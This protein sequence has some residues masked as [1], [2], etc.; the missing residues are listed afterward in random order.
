[1]ATQMETQAIASDYGRADDALAAA[2]AS[3]G[4]GQLKIEGLDS[5]QEQ[6]HLNRENI[7]RCLPFLQD[8]LDAL[9]AIRDAAELGAALRQT[10]GQALGTLV[11]FWTQCVRDLADQDVQLRPG[12][13]PAVCLEP[14]LTDTLELREIMLDAR[15]DLK[16]PRIQG[17]LDQL[18]Q[19]F[20]GVRDTW[21][22][23]TVVE[24]LKAQVLQDAECLSRSKPG[25]GMSKLVRF[26]SLKKRRSSSLSIGQAGQHLLSRCASSIQR[27]A[28]C[29]KQQSSG[30]ATSSWTS[31]LPTKEA[32]ALPKHSLTQQEF[33]KQVDRQDRVMA[34]LLIGDSDPSSGGYVP[35]DDPFS[36]ADQMLRSIQ[37]LQAHPPKDQEHY[38][39]QIT[40]LENLGHR[41]VQ[42]GLFKES[43]AI[44]Q[45]LVAELQQIVSTN[46]GRDYASRFCLA[47]FH[48]ACAL[49]MTERW[50]EAQAAISAAVPISEALSQKQAL[51]TESIRIRC[52]EAVHA[53][54]PAQKD[55]RDV[56]IWTGPPTAGDVPPSADSIPSDRVMAQCQAATELRA[57]FVLLTNRQ[58]VE[59]TKRAERATT[60][61]QSTNRHHSMGHTAALG[62]A[63]FHWGSCGSPAKDL[64]TMTASL[65]SRRVFARTCSS[66]AQYDLARTLEI[67]AY[68]TSVSGNRTEGLNAAKE[69][70]GLYRLL[71]ERQPSVF[72]AI[73]ADN[74][75]RYA[76]MLADSER[77]AEAVEAQ[78]RSLD[79]FRAV[80]KVRPAA[81]KFGLTKR[82]CSLASRLDLL[83]RHDEAIRIGEE[84][85]S[86]ERNLSDAGQQQ[87]RSVPEL[88][89]AL[90][91]QAILYGA[92]KQE[93]AAVKCLQ[94]W[95]DLYNEDPKRMP[96]L[97]AMKMLHC[98]AAQ[99][100]K[101]NRFEEALL[102]MEECVRLARSLHP[103]NKRPPGTK[104]RCVYALRY[105]GYLLH[106]LE[107][108]EAAL[109]AVEEAVTMARDMPLLGNG[110]KRPALGGALIN[111]ATCLEGAERVEEAAEARREGEAIMAASPDWKGHDWSEAVLW[112]GYWRMIDAPYSL[113]VAYGRY[114][115]AAR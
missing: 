96:S 81:F 93:E 115:S 24:Q 18:E 100:C 69:A 101:L 88:M 11:G 19:S 61:L 79:I 90:A 85:V 30:D 37:H 1:M 26:L 35:E 16:Q 4:G 95:V 77:G 98:L 55:N 94:E 47:L 25:T 50:Q 28:E 2:S 108:K 13:R 43:V 54:G 8:Q 83:D 40:A 44:Y 92:G 52:L 64:T 7:Q 68:W 113:P 114:E 51:G 110:K 48:L 109:G 57:Y 74:L 62:S 59:A 104:L 70:V 5:L 9:F 56:Q 76:D 60:L 22:S 58:R 102:P 31:V 103:S 6:T 75:S 45:I 32:C 14:L 36:I 78:T 111:F 33:Y 71:F 41:L 106:A 21:N 10:L 3:G 112:H 107:R 73:F 27:A 38:D 15:A 49:F 29:A 53:I 80:H 42:L 105:Y 39:S 67:Y 91:N 84:Y 17:K 87:A 34:L 82:L 20:S 65:T 46:I 97:S 86:M 23:D 66:K 12:S 89:S 72:A 99:L 63:L